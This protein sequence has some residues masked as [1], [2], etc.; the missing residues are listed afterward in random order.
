[1]K[2]RKLSPETIAKR[3]ATRR[4]NGG[5]AVSESARQKISASLKGR[6]TSPET[7]AKLSASKKGKKRHVIDGDI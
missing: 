4:A 1:M 2:G 6:V 7:R 5:Y 3:T